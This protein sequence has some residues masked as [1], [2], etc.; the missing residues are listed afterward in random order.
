M[1]IDHRGSYVFVPQKILNRSYI[2]TVF[3]QVSRKTVAQRM[4][5]GVFYD[6]D[7]VDRLL[8]KLAEVIF[9][10]MMTPLLAIRAWLEVSS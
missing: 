7:T 4:R 2:R 1:Q 8:E 3:Q 6:A 5:H 9:A 10:D